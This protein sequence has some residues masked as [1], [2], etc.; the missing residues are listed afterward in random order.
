MG[1]IQV[2]KQDKN[3]CYASQQ[4]LSH[5]VE[6]VLCHNGLKKDVTILGHPTVL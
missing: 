6:W 1:H 2:K 5:F 4:Y 3:I